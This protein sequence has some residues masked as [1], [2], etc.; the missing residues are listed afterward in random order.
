M[1]VYAK[2]RLIDAGLEAKWMNKSISARA[3][4]TGYIHYRTQAASLRKIPDV[5]SSLVVPVLG[6][7]NHHIL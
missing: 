3:Y 2:S 5:I 7:L 4:D 6:F 1:F